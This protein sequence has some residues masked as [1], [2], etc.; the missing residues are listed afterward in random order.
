VRVCVEQRAREFEN[1][2][3]ARGAAAGQ[4]RREAG[5]NLIKRV[6]HVVAGQTRQEKTQEDDKQEGRVSLPGPA[7][8]I[9]RPAPAALPCPGSACPLPAPAPGLPAHG[10]ESGSPPATFCNFLQLTPLRHSLIHSLT[11]QLLLTICSYIAKHCTTPSPSPLL[12]ML[13]PLL[14]ALGLSAAASARATS[15][16]A[17]YS[18]YLLCSGVVDYDFHVPNGTTTGA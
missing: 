9:A 15:L 5:V 18:P 12:L 11:V 6:V 7:A 13:V 10:L 17:I 16:P 2:A 3:A 8:K 4:A 1:R 14:G